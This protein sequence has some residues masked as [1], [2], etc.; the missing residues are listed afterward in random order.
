MSG[1]YFRACSDCP[2]MPWMPS[3]FSHIVQ[4]LRLTLLFTHPPHLYMYA[5]Q[6]KPVLMYACM[7]VCL[8][9]RRYCMYMYV[10][11]Y[12]CTYTRMHTCTYERI[13]T[14]VYVCLCT[15]LKPVR[16]KPQRTPKSEQVLETHENNAKALE[17]METRRSPQTPVVTKPQH[18]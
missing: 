14:Y 15:R 13:Y 1:K 8:Q 7:S 2:A 11:M 12:V 16:P 18:L 17:R 6:H 5:I 4:D 9:V 3:Y 10:C